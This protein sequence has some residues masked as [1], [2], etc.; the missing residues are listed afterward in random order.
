M[1]NAAIVIRSRAQPPPSPAWALGPFHHHHC[2]PHSSTSPSAFP[3]QLAPVASATP[4]APPYPFFLSTH[5]PTWADS[6]FQKV[7]L[8]GSQMFLQLVTPEET[9][10]HPVPLTVASSSPLP[11]P[12]EVLSSGSSWGWGMGICPYLSSGSP[13]TRGTQVQSSLANCDSAAAPWLHSEPPASDPVWT[14][15]RATLSHPLPLPIPVPPPSAWMAS[16]HL[17]I[18]LGHHN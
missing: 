13:C 16:L 2:P 6:V 12:P 9:W 14:A 17:C 8:P 4:P 7:P 10:P 18:S 5:Y 1:A 3:S 11:I 15:P